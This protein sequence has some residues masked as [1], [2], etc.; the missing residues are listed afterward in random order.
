MTLENAFISGVQQVAL[1]VRD[2]DKTLEEYTNRLGIGPWWV[3]LYGPPKMT[4]MRI[5]GK[6]ISYSM[7]LALAWTGSTMWE[8]I[9]P[10]D[11]PS[12]YKEFLEAHGEGLH[13]LLVEYDG[14]D[15]DQAIAT[16]TER[17][18]PPLMEGSLGAI[19][20]V[21][22]ETESPLKTVLEIVHRPPGFVR[23]DPD[24]WYPG[25]PEKS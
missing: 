13:H 21:Y 17:G 6:A 1:V 20:F 11:G 19:R 10:V 25:P 22:V 18:C 2:I 12:I 9:E 24:Y 16:F 8:L 4:D 3:S 5:R 23:P 7:K 14:I 15:F